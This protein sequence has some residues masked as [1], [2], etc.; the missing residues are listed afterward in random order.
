MQAQCEIMTM[1]S[2][3]KQ[4]GE[5]LA[6]ALDPGWDS[7]VRQTTTQLAALSGARGKDTYDN[8]VNGRTAPGTDAEHQALMVV[9]T[10]LQ[11]GISEG[12]YVRDER[13]ELHD[14]LDVA[15]KTI[16]Q[17]RNSAKR[18][19]AVGR[20]AHPPQAAIHPPRGS[21]LRPVIAQPHR[22]PIAKLDTHLSLSVCTAFT[23][24]GVA[25]QGLA[26]LIAETH[27]IVLRVDSSLSEWTVNAN[28]LLSELADRLASEGRAAG[29]SMTEFDEMSTVVNKDLAVIDSMHESLFMSGSRIGL[30][31]QLSKVEHWRTSP[32]Q[33]GKRRTES[34]AEHNAQR[35]LWRLENAGFDLRR[36]LR[37]GESKLQAL[38]RDLNAGCSAD[39]TRL[40]IILDGND[41]YP[42]TVLGYLSVLLQE[43]GLAEKSTLFILGAP[44]VAN[45]L[46][47]PGD[48]VFWRDEDIGL[49]SRDGGVS[50]AHWS[51]P[52]WRCPGYT[53]TNLDSELSPER[54]S[55]LSL[56]LIA[57]AIGGS[58]DVE[59]L[60]CLFKIPPSEAAWTAEVLTLYFRT[61]GIVPLD[62]R[63]HAL[64]R[65][66]N[67]DVAHLR[68]AIG[69][70]LG[71]APMRPSVLIAW[72]LI[73]T[74]TTGTT[75]FLDLVMAQLLR[76]DVSELCYF[77]SQLR[78]VATAVGLR[79]L[80]LFEGMLQRAKIA[81]DIAV[82]GV[83]S[84]CVAEY[85]DECCSTLEGKIAD[86]ALAA[87]YYQ[88]AYLRFIDGLLD[89]ADDL[90]TKALVLD[91]TS[92]RNC[93]LRGLIS[94]ARGDI[95]QA[96]ESFNDSISLDNGY[97]YSH[98]NAGVAAE[99]LKELPAAAN[100][101]IDCL[102]LQPDFYEAMF[103][104][105]N[106]LIDLA[107]FAEAATVAELA[108][109]LG[110]VCES[111]VISNLAI[112][113][114][115][116]CYSQVG[117]DLL[118]WADA[119]SHNNV[120][121][122]NIAVTYYARG[123]ASECR[124]W[125]AR[126]NVDHMPQDQAAMVMT[127]KSLCKK[128][129]FSAF[130]VNED[131][132]PKT[133]AAFNINF[134]EF[135][136]YLMEN[137]IRRETK[138]RRRVDQGLGKGKKHPFKHAPES[139]RDK[140]LRRSGQGAIPAITELKVEQAEKEGIMVSYMKVPSNTGG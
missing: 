14:A 27:D 99:K 96:L 95:R 125:L 102:I 33:S 78:L 97:A 127:L 23:P 68:M 87:F 42:E 20:R 17:L 63:R 116:A 59:L 56:A 40:V 124:D 24:R 16:V 21:I 140:L 34:H 118:K 6:R 44:D 83:D 132:T 136:N 107:C 65:L 88:A 108:A 93:N 80:G 51:D 39:H 9:L 129:D 47:W 19:A 128:S 3:R 29:I 66:K 113:L 94:L 111:E 119:I 76:S 105:L 122:Y 58:V 30:L 62:W 28:E 43:T 55:R 137:G 60:Q 81:R 38:L 67:D 49:S 89:A 15:F 120:V 64:N 54:S 117:L 106:V 52:R 57:A 70:S 126:I 45:R 12:K 1:E 77:E 110:P 114:L 82:G 2:A 46:S 48:V 18:Q 85:L 37:F 100:H 53:G 74:L 10:N 101:Y 13:A 121:R 103:N 41:Q 26:S 36:T 61:S 75:N 7:A 69:T 112:G 133:A 90:A 22:P 123:Q 104:L 71:D 73:R 50:A 11:V 131:I 32:Q 8:Y 5:L 115:R 25:T 72:A 35:L 109:A 135:Q 86:S 138:V 4:Y 134:Y 31:A 139:I 130:E 92:H 79:E 98:Y 91:T 84:S